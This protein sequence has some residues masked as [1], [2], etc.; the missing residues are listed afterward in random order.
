MRGW[1]PI[2][3]ALARYWRRHPLQMAL[4]VLGIAL[5]VAVTTGIRLANEGALVSFREG[6][7]ATAGAATHRVFA[8]DGGGVP[9]AAIGRLFRQ[10]P[11]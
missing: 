10:E 7:E 6:I 11:V 1:L 8:P 9:E 2:F 4:T 3:R 5:G